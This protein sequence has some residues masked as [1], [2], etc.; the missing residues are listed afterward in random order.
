VMSALVR[1][2]AIMFVAVSARLL[3]RVLARPNRRGP[4]V[5]SILSFPVAQSDTAAALANP[6]APNHAGQGVVRPQADAGARP[7]A[8]LCGYA[9]GCMSG[10]VALRLP[11]PA[12]QVMR[13]SRNRNWETRTD[14]LLERFWR[15]CQEGRLEWPLGRRHVA[16]AGGPTISGHASHQNR[17]GCRHLVHAH[18]DHVLSR[19]E[20][21]TTERELVAPM[22][23]VDREV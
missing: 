10:A 22:S 3:L 11:G 6:D 23:S 13:L 14:R 1:S 15:E 9:D 20:R 7:R 16:A 21:E 4:Q 18:A 19:E 5:P 17:T 12:W 2:L 8:R